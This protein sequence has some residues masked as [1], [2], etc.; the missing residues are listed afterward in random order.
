MTNTNF[1]GDVETATHNRVFELTARAGYTISGVLHLLVAYIIARIAIGSGGTADQSGALAT[2]AGHTGGALALWIAAVA[3]VAMAL[4]RLAESVV[5]QHPSEWSKH[6]SGTVQRLKALGLAVVYLAL[7][8][9]ALT[10]AVRSGKSSDQQNASP[11]DLEQDR[12]Q[13]NDHEQRTD[14]RGEVDPDR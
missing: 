10:F 1:Q 12:H 13:R 9:S 5:G 11:V 2:V 14:R 3:L 4:W 7:A 8:Y 6:D